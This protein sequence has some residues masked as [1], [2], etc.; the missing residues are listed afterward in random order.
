MVKNE[1]DSEWQS[2]FD[3]S[4]VINQLNLPYLDLVETDDPPNV[5]VTCRAAV[6]PQI[7]GVQ[8]NDIFDQVFMNEADTGTHE[9]ERFLVKKVASRT[10]SKHLPEHQ[11][12]RE[13]ILFNFYLFPNSYFFKNFW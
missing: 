13:K 7:A 1:V 9:L 2:V 8:T 3:K 6:L 4:A 12:I 10:I 11:K 5:I